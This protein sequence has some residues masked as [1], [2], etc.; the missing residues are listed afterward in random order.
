MR[1][2]QHKKH[3]NI[4]G[5]WYDAETQTLKVQFEKGSG[6]YANV[7]Q[8][9]VDRIEA[10]TDNVGKIVGELRKNPQ[11]YPWTSID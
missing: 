6:T 7:P 9:F 2:L 5:I 10:E 11:S 8:T 1:Q 4:Q 3:Y